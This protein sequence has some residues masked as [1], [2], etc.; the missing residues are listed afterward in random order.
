MRQSVTIA[1]RDFF[2]EE[3]F[4]CGVEFAMPLMLRETCF[5]DKQWFFCP[6]GH[7]QAYVESLRETLARVRK[8]L[9][10]AIEARDRAEQKVNELKS[11]AHRGVCAFCHRT[12]QNVARHMKTKHPKS[13]P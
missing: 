5:R 13:A 9:G 8:D 3:C 11:R 7:S 10:E 4:K 1:M 6:N 2:V 12:F